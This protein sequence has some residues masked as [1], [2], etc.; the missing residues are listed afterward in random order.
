M[1]SQVK[2]VFLDTYI[3]TR[4]TLGNENAPSYDNY[5]NKSLIL[6]VLATTGLPS[7]LKSLPNSNESKGLRKQGFFQSGAHKLI[8]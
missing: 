2:S 8:D 7:M 1:F 6:F 5:C 4:A 3:L